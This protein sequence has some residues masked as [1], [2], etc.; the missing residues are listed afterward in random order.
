MQRAKGAGSGQTSKTKNLHR[1]GKPKGSHPVKRYALL[2][3]V[4]AVH[5]EWTHGRRNAL[6]DGERGKGSDG[7]TGLVGESG[8][9]D[10]CC[11]PSPSSAA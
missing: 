5:S 6:E 4:G 11:S 1:V 2:P 8:A 7:V 3:A 9:G 10:V